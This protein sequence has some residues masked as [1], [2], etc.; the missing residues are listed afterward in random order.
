METFRIERD[1]SQ[2]LK[3]L[4][5]KLLNSDTSKDVT[6]IGNDN[7]A[8]EANKFV[9]NGHSQVFESLLSSSSHPHPLIFFPHLPGPLLRDVINFIYTGQANVQQDD[10]K[11][12]FALCRTFKVEGIDNMAEPA[13]EKHLEVEAKKSYSEVSNNV[14][15]LKLSKFVK[16]VNHDISEYDIKKDIDVEN[17]NLV[18]QFFE[19]KSTENVKKIKK[20]T[21]VK[22][23]SRLKSI[24]PNPEGQYECHL[25]S[26]K[27]FKRERMLVHIP[28]NHGPKKY[29]CEICDFTSRAKR[30]VKDHVGIKHFNVRHEC[31]QC[32]YKA[33]YK[34]HLVKH[35]ISQHVLNFKISCT[36]CEYFGKSRTEVK[37]HVEKIHKV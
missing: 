30:Q 22:N 3:Q 4:F 2:I 11:D 18:E 32:E 29:K 37:Q 16:E 33:N 25:C 35:K 26:Y 9:L 23:K 34:N 1:N 10:I 7:I 8:I 20:T 31:D 27:S 6:L 12:F 28:R 24:R 14:D 19:D 36:M 13:I 21:S 5:Q 17:S 15:N